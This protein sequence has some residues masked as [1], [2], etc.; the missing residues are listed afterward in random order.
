[1]ILLQIQVILLAALNFLLTNK[2]LMM[3]MMMMMMVNCFCGMVD[4]KRRLDLFPA[5]TIIRGPHHRE[6]LARRVQDLS[7]HRI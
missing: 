1:M 2:L 3:M 6:S 7:F 5:G 4:D